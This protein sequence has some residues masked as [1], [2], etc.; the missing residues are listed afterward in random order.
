MNNKREKKAHIWERDGFDWYVEPEVA[1]AA[2]LKVERFVGRIHDPSCGQGN[3]VRTLI[4]HGYHASGS[5][6]VDR[7]GSPGWFRGKSDFLG[8][9]PMYAENM[10]FNPPFYKAKGAEA[11][12]RRAL[13]VATGKVAAFVDMKFL[14]GAARAK[15][16]Y[17]EHPPSRVWI[18]TPRV[19]CPPGEALLAGEKAQGGEADWCW[20][21][22]DKT[23]QPGAT[24]MNWLRPA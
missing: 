20:M 9:E 7:A 19:S 16:L 11:F 12:I 24:V 14:A 21:I 8:A 13:Q 10:A 18:V 6:L 5:D 15:G 3:I 4:Q 1:T 23:A 2:L 22:W 17:V